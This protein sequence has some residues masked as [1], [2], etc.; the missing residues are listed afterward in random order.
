MNGRICPAVRGNE[1][2][3]EAMDGMT[4][5]MWI[6]DI[7]GATVMGLALLSAATKRQRPINRM[8]D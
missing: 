4:T 3:I 6:V 1:R 5:A 8:G 2:E 7:F